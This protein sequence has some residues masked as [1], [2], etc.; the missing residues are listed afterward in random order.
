MSKYRLLTKSDIDGIIC[1]ALLKSAELIDDVVFVNSFDFENGE[2]EVNDNDITCNLPYSDKVALSF[3]YAKKSIAKNNI[4]DITSESCAEN[5]YRYYKK[6]M[7]E[8]DKDRVKGLIYSAKKSNL[9]KFSRT[10]VLEPKGFDMLSFLLDSRTGI[11]RVRA[12]RISNYALMMKLANEVLEKDID[13]IMESE[14]IKERIE[15]YFESQEDYEEMIKV[16]SKENNS[17]L[18]VDLR[19]ETYIKP[20]NRFV[21]Y[22]M[23]PDAKFS[24]QVMWGLRRKNTVL[25]VGKSI[26]GKKSDIDL[27]AILKKYDGIS[28]RNS[29]S[30]QIDNDKVEEVLGSLIADLSQ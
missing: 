7:Q 2:I 22:A 8:V 27:E 23:Y 19:D 4:S 26:F 15:Y 13:E 9:A 20:A 25:A 24:I 6:E 5:V 3:N 28:R 14:D 10:E 30:I 1:A 17:I 21:K 16:C 11:G 12:F 29:G 18:I